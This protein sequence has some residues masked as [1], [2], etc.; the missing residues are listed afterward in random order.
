MH[1][2]GVKPRQAT[3]DRVLCH[4]IFTLYITL[5]TLVSFVSS[6]MVCAFV[7]V[8]GFWGVGGEGGGGFDPSYL[9]TVCRKT[10]LKLLSSPLHSYELS[11]GD[12]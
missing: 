12:E 9:Q 5:R 6:L 10:V 2:L 3:V 7:K 11:E 8:E 1:L 4:L